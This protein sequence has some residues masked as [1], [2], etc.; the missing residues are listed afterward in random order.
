MPRYCRWVTDFQLCVG[1]AALKCALTEIDARH[2]S[3]LTVTQCCNTYTVFFRR[4][5]GG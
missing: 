2:Y 3:L 1:E 4:P 5:Y